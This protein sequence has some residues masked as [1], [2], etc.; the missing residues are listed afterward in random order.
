MGWLILSVVIGSIGQLFFKMAAGHGRDSSAIPHYYFTL[1]MNPYLWLGLFCYG[2]SL[3]LWLWILQKY[4][5]SFAYPM[6]GLGYVITTVLA[7]LFLGE[8]VT[9]LRWMGILLIVAGIFMLN[10]SRSM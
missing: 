2:L 7:I 5:L 8:G 3:L 1:L 6:V 10:M 9:L 4:E